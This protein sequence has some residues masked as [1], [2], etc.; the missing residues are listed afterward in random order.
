MHVIC[1]KS[2]DQ[3]YVICVHVILQEFFYPLCLLPTTLSLRL[4]DTA[5][6]AP[7]PPHQR[8]PEVDLLKVRALRMIPA[9]RTRRV[10]S[11]RDS[12]HTSTGPLLLAQLLRRERRFMST[13]MRSSIRSSMRTGSGA[14]TGRPTLCQGKYNHMV[15]Q[16]HLLPSWDCVLYPFFWLPSSEQTLQSWLFV[17]LIVG[18]T[19]QL[20]AS[21]WCT[22]CV[23]VDW[24]KVSLTKEHVTL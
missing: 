11:P 7:Q 10:S 18:E 22:V 14:L 23:Y 12:P 24:V 6:S 13:S 8:T 9:L 21:L 15:R 2:C 16:C 3:K 4:M 19:I 17:W 1:W 20:P 5:A